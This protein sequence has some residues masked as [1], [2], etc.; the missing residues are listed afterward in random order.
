MK[1]LA[2]ALILAASHPS[3]ADQGFGDRSCADTE[4]LAKLRESIYEGDFPTSPGYISID[5]LFRAQL[6]VKRVLFGPAKPGLLSV[7]YTAHNYLNG[8]SGYFLIYLNSN[9]GHGWTIARC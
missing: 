5:G 8:S 9:D 1:A 7:E 2:A 6:T 3:H 4:V